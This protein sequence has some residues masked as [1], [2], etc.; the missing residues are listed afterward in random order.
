MPVVWTP[1][2]HQTVGHNTISISVLVDEDHHSQGHSLISPAYQ[3]QYPQKTVSYPRQTYIWNCRST[4]RV[5][6]RAAGVQC[7]GILIY[8]RMWTYIFLWFSICF[9]GSVTIYITIQNAESKFGPIFGDAPTCRSYTP[10]SN[11]IWNRQC[12]CFIGICA[13]KQTVSMGM[14]RYTTLGSCNMCFDLIYWVWIVVD[15]AC[16]P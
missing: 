5:G 4:G 12:E 10:V 1:L 3:S 13:D 8:V 16:R 15:M 2:K 11:C 14:T 6:S 9:H 7:D